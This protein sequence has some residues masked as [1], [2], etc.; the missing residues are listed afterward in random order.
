MKNLF[1]SFISIHP[2]RAKNDTIIMKM[3][4]IILFGPAGLKGM[5]ALSIMVNAGVDSCNLAAAA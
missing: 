4:I 3:E 2:E 5:D 1:H